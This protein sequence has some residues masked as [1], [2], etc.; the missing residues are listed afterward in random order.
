MTQ[1]RHIMKYIRH[2][3]NRIDFGMHDE[4]RLWTF[5]FLISANSGL[6]IEPEYFFHKEIIFR[7]L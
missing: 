3:L 1:I 4:V 6:L 5:L 7:Y 2:L